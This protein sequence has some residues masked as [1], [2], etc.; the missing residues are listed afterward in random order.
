MLVKKFKIN[1]IRFG[2]RRKVFCKLFHDI[3]YKEK[4]SFHEMNAF[5]HSRDFWESVEK[6][7]TNH[8]LSA[9]E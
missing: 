4:S 8:L 3:Q 7:L 2:R 5:L 9:W 6:R 1:L